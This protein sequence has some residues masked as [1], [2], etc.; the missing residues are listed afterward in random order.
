[1]GE[2]GSFSWA[3]IAGAE[4]VKMLEKDF[5]V[6]AE[7]EVLINKN[8]EN[9]RHSEAVSNSWK[10]L[11]FY[12]EF[13]RLYT[14]MQISS[15]GENNLE[16]TRENC[17]KLTDYVN[18]NEHILHPVI[19]GFMFRARLGDDYKKIGVGEDVHK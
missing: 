19:D 15:L 12:P 1:M 17:D 10:Y 4:T 3:K 14:N 6:I 8:T 13:A 2:Q 7:L 11:K 16:K 5:D 9:N 18:K